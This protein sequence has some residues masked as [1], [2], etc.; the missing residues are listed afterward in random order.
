[1]HGFSGKA[2]EAWKETKA[3]EETLE[4]EGS[5][6]HWERG[7][8]RLHLCTSETQERDLGWKKRLGSSST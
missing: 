7:P 5:I 8:V 6:E 3:L 2:E 4:P 1:M